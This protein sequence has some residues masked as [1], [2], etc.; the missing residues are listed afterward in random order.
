ILEALHVERLDPAHVIVGPP[1]LAQLRR[2]IAPGSLEEWDEILAGNVDYAVKLRLLGLHDADVVCIGESFSSSNHAQRLSP[3][4][5]TRMYKMRMTTT[6]LYPHPSRT[7]QPM[8]R[9]PDRGYHHPGRDDRR[10]T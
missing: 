9:D 3:I 6:G 8:D 2:P 7:L 1:L 10:H 5:T 4:L